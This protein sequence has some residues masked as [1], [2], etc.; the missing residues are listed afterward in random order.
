MDD[1]KAA[2]QQG[3]ATQ[4]LATGWASSPAIAAGSS[5][6]PASS[7]MSND[8]FHAPFRSYSSSRGGHLAVIGPQ[9]FTGEV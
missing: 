2:Q 5:N 7:M 6:R 8:G 4:S 1:L 3:N 9:Q